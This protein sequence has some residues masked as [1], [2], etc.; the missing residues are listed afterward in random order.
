MEMVS[1]MTHIDELLSDDV[2][3]F[4]QDHG[5]LEYVEMAIKS[6]REVFADAVRIGA[7]VRED[8]EFGFPYVDV[9]VVL[10][11]DEKPETEIEKYSEC[12]LK[13]APHIPP[14]L[15]GLVHLSTSWPS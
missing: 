3:K 10:H 6:A 9:H 12:T 5:I 8:Q 14:D 13:W 15:G 7:T 4:A 2:V 1:K 11:A